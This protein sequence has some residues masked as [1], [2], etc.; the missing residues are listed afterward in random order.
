M[1]KLEYL[2]SY[3]ADLEPPVE[4]G[5]V[6]FGTRQIFDVKGGT[7]DGPR[8]KGKLLPSGGDWLLLGHDGVGRLDVRGTLETDDGARIYIQYFGIIVLNEKAAQAL[9]EGRET[10]Y[11]DTYFMTQPRFE[12]GDPSYAWLN[13]IVAVA[14]GRV[15]QNAVEYRVF[16]VVND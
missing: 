5:A 2:C 1:A 12:T 13:S 11:G 10:S 16:Q 9:A 14:E 6:P 7:C 3:R 15:L 4:I 8:L